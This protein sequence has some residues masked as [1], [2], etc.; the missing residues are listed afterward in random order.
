MMLLYV[1]CPIVVALTSTQ[2]FQLLPAAAT[3][4]ALVLAHVRRR[5]F[6]VPSIVLTFCCVAFAVGSK[7]FFTVSGALVVGYCFFA[8]HRT[9]NLRQA[10][11]IAPVVFLALAGPLYITN[12]V[13]YGD[14]VWPLLDNINSLPDQ[15]LA[16]FVERGLRVASDTGA[17]A[18]LP[19]D[20]VFP[21]HLGGLAQVLGVGTLVFVL[22]VRSKHVIASL[23]FLALAASVLSYSLRTQFTA[24][25]FLEPYWWSVA[26][27]ARVEWTWRKRWLQNAMLAQ[28]FVIGVLAVYGA[29]I[30]FPGALSGNL[31]ERVLS[32]K[33]Y[34]YS[35]AQWI[36]A[37]VRDTS[38]AFVVPGNVSYAH[39]SIPFY[40][41]DGWN[42]VSGYA[43]EDEVKNAVEEVILELAKLN[44]DVMFAGYPADNPVV[45]YLSECYSDKPGITHDFSVVTR[46]PFN[47]GGKSIYQLL[48][49]DLT[50][51]ACN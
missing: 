5:R 46:N 20:L 27:T 7:Y 49:I 17:P 50:K 22:G 26:A 25:Y 21:R 10:M 35:S 36:N 42:Y 16:G 23:L 43:S 33:A 9:G 34:G 47:T 48:P 19:T 44:V 4:T 11:I 37:Q 28:A 3:T 39:L 30:L 29:S 40:N 41:F 38:A 45:R 24:R 6:D 18:T 31:R 2:K 51:S 12:M 8:A 13:L 15:N 32:E 1:A 14:P